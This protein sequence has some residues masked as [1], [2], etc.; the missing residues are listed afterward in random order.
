MVHTVR[1][2]GPLSPKSFTQTHFPRLRHC[3]QTTLFSSF[4]HAS[5]PIPRLFYLVC[6]H[7]CFLPSSRPTYPLVP[8]A[9]LLSSYSL[10]PLLSFTCSRLLHCSP[11]Q[12]FFRSRSE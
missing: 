1:M 10:E 12:H 4:H 3:I 5:L 2:H 7:K 11:L 8:L 9:G 6:L